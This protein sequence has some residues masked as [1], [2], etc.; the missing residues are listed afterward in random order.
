MRLG[1]GLSTSIPGAECPMIHVECVTKSY[2]HSSGPVSV[3]RGVTC[4]F[5]TGS[6]SIILGP[7]GSGKSTLL[8]LLGALD[9]PTS[10]EIYI[11]GRS[12]GAMSTSQQNQFRRSEVGFIFQSFNLLSNLN[13]LDNVLVPFI[14]AGISPA[15]KKRAGEL[16]DRVGLCSRWH[17]RPSQLS[18][19]E[20]QRVAIA[21]AILK[22]PRLILADEPTG[23]LD[24]ETGQLV[25]QLLRELQQDHGTTL[26][27]VTHDDRYLLPTDH[28]FRIESGQLISKS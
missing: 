18:G 9:R 1:L 19:G 6:C 24:G 8:Y 3:L 28:I 23:E 7:S 2:H 12:V 26:I 4:D 21:R 22:S 20:Q 16:L 14:P 25:F 10:G 15:L 11:E 13:A 27:V 17:H 5:Q